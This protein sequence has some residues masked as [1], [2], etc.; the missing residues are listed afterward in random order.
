M[1]IKLVTDANMWIWIVSLCGFIF[2]VINFFLGKYVATKITGND[3][4][5]LTADV[6]ELKKSEKEYKSFLREDLNKIFR[7]LGHIEKQIVKREAVCNE[8]HRKI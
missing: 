3:L 6:K 8:R 1:N 4:V 7:R 5:H 2:S